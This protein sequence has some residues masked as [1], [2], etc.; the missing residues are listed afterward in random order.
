VV[1]AGVLGAG[2]VDPDASDAGTTGL[3][4]VGRQVR[5]DE[6]LVPVLLPLGDGMLAAVKVGSA[7]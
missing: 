7:A 3:R 4:E 1:F 6:R 5:E 2:V